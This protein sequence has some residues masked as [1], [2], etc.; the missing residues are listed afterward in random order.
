MPKN[1]PTPTF[2]PDTRQKI[3]ISLRGRLIT[4]LDRA[5]LDEKGRS[6]VNVNRNELVEAIIEVADLETA[7]RKLAERG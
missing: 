4:A 1:Q 2:N 3:T 7:A 6:G 5:A